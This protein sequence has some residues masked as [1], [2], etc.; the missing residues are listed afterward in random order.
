MFEL[1]YFGQPAEEPA[2]TEVPV[3][4]R[5]PIILTAIL[6]LVFGIFAYLPLDYVVGPAV[7]ALLGR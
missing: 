6:S 1:I 3:S 5:L 2:V 4:M 7:E